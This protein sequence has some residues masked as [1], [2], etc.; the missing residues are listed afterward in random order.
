MIHPVTQQQLTII[1]NEKYE[2]GEIMT[3]D[4]ENVLRSQDQHHRNMETKA[5]FEE[6]EVL[7]ML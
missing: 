5:S 3:K 2:I 7:T 4:R 1:I 6:G